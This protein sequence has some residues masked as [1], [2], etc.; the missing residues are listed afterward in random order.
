MQDENSSNKAHEIALFI[1]I[2]IAHICG[3]LYSDNFINRR[4]IFCSNISNEIIF[5]GNL[6]PTDGKTS[7]MIRLIMQQW[8]LQKAVIIVA[9]KSYQL[10]ANCSVEIEEIGDTSCNEL[11]ELAPNAKL[12]ITLLSYSIGAGGGSVLII[13]ILV[14]LSVIV[15]CCVKWKRL[16]KSKYTVR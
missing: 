10:D 16:K 3:C 4:K 9:G 14:V 5:Q 6:L 7:E 12:G 11:T 13:M 8:V 15:A 1:G 2:Q